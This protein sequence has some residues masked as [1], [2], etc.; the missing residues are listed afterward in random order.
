MKLTLIRNKYT[1][2]ST[3]G[4]LLIDGEPFCYTL[5]DKVR[6]NKIPKITA[7]DA[8]K[9]K[10]ELTMSNRFKEIMPILLDVPN[11]TG[12]RIHRG[13]TDKD[14]EGCILVGLDRGRDIIL[15]STQAFNDL[16]EVLTEEKNICIEIVDTIELGCG[17]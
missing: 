8:G 17:L 7:I 10:V 1:D 5:E 16:M 15:N 11:F 9:Y 6:I 3:I 4:E 13:N 14:T 12:I 2:Y